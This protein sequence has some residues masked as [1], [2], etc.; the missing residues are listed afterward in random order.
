MSREGIET[1]KY[2]SGNGIVKLRIGI[3]KQRKAN[4]SDGGRGWV[5]G[6]GAIE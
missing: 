4:L 5:E 3:K 1:E 2:R 6:G